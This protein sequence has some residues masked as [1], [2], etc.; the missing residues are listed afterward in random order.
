MHKSYNHTVSFIRLLSMLMIIS[1]HIFQYYD[2]VL[3]YVLN[4]GVQV[5]LVMSGYLYGT[6]EIDSVKS[7][8]IK[9]FKKILVPYYVFLIFAICLYYFSA[10]QYLDY[11]K[12]VLSF[13]T[14]GNLDGLGHLWFIKYILLCYLLVP[15][16]V[17]IRDRINTLELKYFAYVCVLTMIVVEFILL[18]MPLLGGMSVNCFVFGFF[19]SNFDRCGGRRTLFPKVFVVCAVCI[20]IF[21]VILISNRFFRR[22]LSFYVW[23]SIVYIS[24]FLLRC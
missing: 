22:I 17:R 8:Y 21:R 12:V 5:F 4:V 14:V 24:S 11:K 19:F 18:P 16:L 1:C 20:N 10:P 13:L 9:Q 7:F 23:C 3:A 15:I 6:K 2:H